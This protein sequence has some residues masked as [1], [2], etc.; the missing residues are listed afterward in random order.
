MTARCP[1]AAGWYFFEVDGW[2]SRK[3]SE[4]L[5][6]VGRK[7]GQAVR[8]EAGD[9]VR[10]GRSGKVGAGAGMKRGLQVGGGIRRG[11]WRVG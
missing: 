6:A 4:G 5:L 2:S 3:E 9:S 1:S 7:C 10:E 8:V 11:G